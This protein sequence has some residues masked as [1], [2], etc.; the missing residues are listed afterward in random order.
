MAGPKE[1]PHVLDVIFD[2][3]AK[4]QKINKEK[5]RNGEAISHAFL[6]MLISYGQNIQISFSDSFSPEFRKETPVITVNTK[7]RDIPVK[8]VE[9]RRPVSPDYRMGPMQIGKK[10]PL[11]DGGFAIVSGTEN[12]YSVDENNKTQNWLGKA[13][14]P[15]QDEMVLTQLIPLIQE[16]FAKL[17]KIFEVAPSEGGIDALH[18]FTDKRKE[19]T[20]TTLPEVRILD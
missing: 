4:N 11:V 2:D 9:I 7:D 17:P 13:A 6:G 12:L 20:T 18:R 8:I 14:T 10:Y 5:T 19:H 3:I 1:N 15:E 16:E